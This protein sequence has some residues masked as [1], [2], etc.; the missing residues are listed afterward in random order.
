M[1]HPGILVSYH[2]LR[3][4][5]YFGRRLDSLFNIF[6]GLPVV[7]DSGAY[8]ARQSG[9]DVPLMEFGKFIRK[10]GHRFHWVASLDVIGNPHVTRTNWQMLNRY[11]PVV[12]TIHAGTDLDY[13]R[14]Y[15]SQGVERIAFGGMV[16]ENGFAQLARNT[17][18]IRAWLDD[19]FL[20]LANHQQVQVH[21]FGLTNLEVLDPYPWTTADSTS[22][23]MRTMF[24]NICVSKGKYWRP[25]DPET[26]PA[27]VARQAFAK[28][29][30][31]PGKTR[32]YRYSTNVFTLTKHLENC[33]IR[34][35]YHALNPNGRDEH[36]AAQGCSWYRNGAAT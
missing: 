13:L 2:Y 3:K 18:D 35:V 34:H 33:G 4:G 1:I 12:P 22:A 36:A 23:L 29:E 9:A 15:L 21:A 25:V 10:E 32:A 30:V 24:G 27:D 8:S 26:L 17:S 31:I 20:L 28:F 14:F 5:R 19:A 11:Y 6:Q 16:G 7:L